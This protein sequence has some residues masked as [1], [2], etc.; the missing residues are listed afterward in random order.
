VERAIRKPAV[1]A[2]SVSADSV[3]GFFVPEPVVARKQIPA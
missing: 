2:V 1:L 3:S